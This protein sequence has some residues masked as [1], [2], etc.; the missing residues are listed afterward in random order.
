MPSKATS[1]NLATHWLP[2]VEQ[3]RHSGQSQK[4]FC[5]EHELNYDQF[6]Y[7][8]RKLAQP[9]EA[10]AQRATSAL[11]PVTCTP[12]AT[13]QGLSLRLPNGMELR[14]L[15]QDNLPVVQQLLAQLQ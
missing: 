13:G 3:W 14:G 10:A 9:V 6:V 4:A 12:L 2:L 1:E 15:T 8:R 7:W 5:R 11:V